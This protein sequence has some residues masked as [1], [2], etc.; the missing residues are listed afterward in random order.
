MVHF[1]S[2]GNDSDTN[3]NYP[4]SL[5]SVNSIAAV[6]DDGNLASFSDSGTGLAFTAPGDDIWTTDRTGSDGGSNSDYALVDGTSFASPYAAGVAALVLSVDDLLGAAEVEQIM[7]DTARDLGA[8]GYDTTFGWG[9]VNA[10]QALLGTVGAHLDVKPGSC[11][12]P[13]NRNSN[14]VIPIALIGTASFNVANV[15]LPTVRLWRADG[16]GEGVAPNEGPPG[17]HTVIADVATPFDGDTCECD[18]LAGDGIPDLSMKFRTQDVV[19]GLQLNDL[20]MGEMVGFMLT[21]NMLDGTPF[22]AIDC[23]TLVPP[24]SLAVSSNL[25]GLW[26]DVSPDDD[27]SQGGGFTPFNR[28]F[29]QTESV[30]ITPLVP[31]AFPGWSLLGWVVDGVFVPASGET[32]EFPID[33]DTQSVAVWYHMLS[34]LDIAPGEGSRSTD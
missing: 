5:A 13:I 30:T 32:L 22:G 23:I 25:A 21:G 11:P 10:N 24:G 4:S 3:I 28:V 31:G 34:D 14:G 16:A 20:D 1:A 33:A 7:Q 9:L 6:N 27:D 19:G 18:E 8:P 2:A 17:P 26:V 15:N 12:N 29:P